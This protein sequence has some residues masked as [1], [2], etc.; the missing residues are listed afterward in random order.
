MRAER[1]VE[2]LYRAMKIVRAIPEGSFWMVTVTDQDGANGSTGCLNV[3]TSHPL[4]VIEKLGGEWERIPGEGPRSLSL[5][6]TRMDGLLEVTVEG[7]LQ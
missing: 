3:T 7:F 5:S 6:Y 4:A 2:L 1:Q